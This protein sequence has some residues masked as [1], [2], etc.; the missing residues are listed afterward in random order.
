LL[1]FLAP[2]ISAQNT[3]E[4][5][6]YR[7]R[8]ESRSFDPSNPAARSSH[9]STLQ[10]PVTQAGY[11]R[12]N[13]FAETPTDVRSQAEPNLSSAN[14][15][16]ANLSS[17]NLSSANRSP[18]NGSLAAGYRPAES[19][20]TELAADGISLAPP[21]ES[22]GSQISQPKSSL[23]TFVTMLAALAIVIGVFF[24]LTFLLKKTGAGGP[25]LSAL[26]RDVVQILGRTP[27]GPRQQLI[28]M[29]LGNK[30][31]LVSQQSGHT[32]TIAEVDD[33]LEVDRMCGLIEQSST[34]SV[35]QSFRDVF[36]QLATK[37]SG[38][39]PRLKGSRKQGATNV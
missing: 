11:T 7:P 2:V 39:L 36:Q 18:A 4:A 37:S 26:P 5:Q 10:T 34:T 32:E 31:V 1:V 6:L 9:N 12:S 3:N 13:N 20:D 24:G 17:A 38:S 8:V 21:S 28:L 25:G 23:G 30:L 19:S 16:S 33:P 35:S 27:F 22:I 14:L 15:S 29:R